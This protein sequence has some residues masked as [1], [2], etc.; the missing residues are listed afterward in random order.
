MDIVE[1]IRA[2]ANATEELH[3][4]DSEIAVM[5]NAAYEIERLR[6][7]LTQCAATFDSG[8]CTVVQ[9]YQLAAQELQRRIN[10]AGEALNQ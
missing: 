6:G 2:E 9:G 4:E 8:P 7:V 5:R 1:Q 10:I 3:P